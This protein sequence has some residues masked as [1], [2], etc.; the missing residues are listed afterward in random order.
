MAVY[1]VGPLSTQQLRRRRQTAAL[2]LLLSVAAA[3]LTAFYGGRYEAALP[4]IR[5]A[6]FI[7]LP[8]WVVV[9]ACSLIVL[10]TQKGMARVRESIEFEI[11]QLGVS[12]FQAG[13]GDYSAISLNLTDAPDVTRRQTRIGSN[14]L[15]RDAILGFELRKNGNLLLIAKPWP[16][17]LVVPHDLIG[18]DGFRRELLEQGIAEI[19]LRG[20]Q[21]F[22][23]RWTGLLIL[24]P[25]VLSSFYIFVG[26]NPYL[27]VLS[28]AF[29]G[30]VMFAAHI[31]PR[32]FPSNRPRSTG[33]PQA[34]LVS[35]VLFMALVRAWTVA[36]PR[37]HRA[38]T[39]PCSV[40][41]K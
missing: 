29:Y 8:C 6:L 10:L 26:R 23:R 11:S 38:A 32:L 9:A 5:L 20:W 2:F 27:V 22:F 15:A 3:A 14:F 30:V 37:A 13:I 4:W 17:A 36:H 28:G 40:T 18:L 31:F 41:G 21:A 19:Q 12:R 33:L 39:A 1:R 7:L 25:A 24:A 16:R 34:L 35:A